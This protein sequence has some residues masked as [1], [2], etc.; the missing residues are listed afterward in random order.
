[1]VLDLSGASIASSW[2]GTFESAQ[3]R[4]TITPASWNRELAPGSTTTLG[5]CASHA[6]G[7]STPVPVIIATES[8]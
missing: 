5:Y 4:T 7:S 8:S 3:G 6:S 2:S 1:V